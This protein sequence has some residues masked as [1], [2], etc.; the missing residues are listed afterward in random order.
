MGKQ[1]KGKAPTRRAAG[2]TQARL[3]PAAQERIGAQLRAMYDEIVNEGVPDRFAKL[4]DKLDTR[5][6]A[7]KD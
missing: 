5:R 7:G 3:D 4:I 1:T 2:E 6:D